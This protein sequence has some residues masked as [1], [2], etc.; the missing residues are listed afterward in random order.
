MKPSLHRRL[1]LWVAS[2]SAATLILALLVTFSLVKSQLR[3]QFDD[4]LQSRMRNVTQLVEQNN[5]SIDFEWNE[6]GSPLSPIASPGDRLTFWASGTIIQVY[7]ND[8]A[9]LQRPQQMERIEPIDFGG[10][11]Y[12]LGAVQFVP[13]REHGDDSQ[14]ISVTFAMAA[15]TK[16]L[17][18]TLA[19]IW[20]SLCGALLFGLVLVVLGTLLAVSRGLQPLSATADEITAHANEDLSFRFQAVDQRP[21]EL[22]PLLNRLNN[23]FER[24]E[25]VID[26]ERA[27]SSEIA[28]ELRTPL[29]GLR[30]KIDV[31]LSKPR[32][33]EHFKVTLDGCREIVLQTSLI[34]ESLL[35]TATP[36][37]HNERRQSSNLS[38]EIEHTLIE[39]G[40]LADIREL[41]VRSEIIPAVYVE[42]DKYQLRIVLRNVIA[43]AVAYADA[44]TE[45]HIDCS[46]IGSEA[47]VRINNA[48]HGFS[49]DWT[50]K[51]FDRFWRADTSRTET[52]IH[53]GL[54]LPLAKRVVEQTGGKISAHYK[55]GRFTLTIVWKAAE[56]APAN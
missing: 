15:P 41:S 47:V 5:G 22:K 56:V 14:S 36:A 48:S 21:E 25:S 23:L 51:V 45:I 1:L 9:P 42:V 34:V 54:G 43:N 31:A 29:A 55:D 46:I 10:A 4:A 50:D 18:S 7:P 24:L 38:S 16:E 13:R 44:Q 6:A 39:L 32:S 33:A 28:H 37:K 8:S 52:G 26:R 53:A 35:A 12:R 2:T 11:P 20:W 3:R 17:E 27:F 30:A 19:T 40:E 49:A